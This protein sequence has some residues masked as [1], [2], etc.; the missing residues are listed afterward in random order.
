[1]SGRR[2]IFLWFTCMVVAFEVGFGSMLFL[3]C[4]FGIYDYVDKAI[5]ARNSLK[6][7]MVAGELVC[8]F[9]SCGLMGARP[10]IMKY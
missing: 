8:A 2:F 9:V 5:H 1:M 4:S 3:Q 10:W 7:C 6:I